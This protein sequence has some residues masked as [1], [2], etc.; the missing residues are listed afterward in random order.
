[1]LDSNIQ[2][3]LKTYFEKISHPVVLSASLDQS[4]KS[5]E[6]LTLLK[7]IEALSDKI[8]L[9]MDGQ[10]LNSQALASLLQAVRLAFT[11]L[12][13]PWGTR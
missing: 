10:A 8:S 7:E 11:L 13:C 1:M 5:S 4:E 6:M 2:S 3:Q 12:A 9:N